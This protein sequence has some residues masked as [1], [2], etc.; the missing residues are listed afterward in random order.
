MITVRRARCKI[1]TL[2]FVLLIAFPIRA[3]AWD[4]KAHQI[5]GALAWM[6]LS[7]GVKRQ[8]LNLLPPEASKDPDGPLAA[9]STWADRQRVAYREQ[10]SWH[11]V[12]IPLSESKFDWNRD[13]ANHNCI[14]AQLDEK[15]NA[16]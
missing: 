7:E 16:L 1:L 3:F 12:G 5:I 8:V 13:C 4:D 14:V 10:A 6:K 15:K 11:F 9:V 2:T